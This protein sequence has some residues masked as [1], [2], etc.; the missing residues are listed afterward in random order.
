MIEFS[1]ID[2]EICPSLRNKYSEKFIDEFCKLYK[3]RF[4]KH[5]DYVNKDYVDAIKYTVKYLEKGEH[6]NMENK[7]L[8]WKEIEELANKRGYTLY[9]ST[10][11]VD[12]T[13]NFI[14]NFMEPITSERLNEGKM[15]VRLHLDV[16][17]R[18]NKVEFR[19]THLTVK[20]AC[21]FTT[22]WCGSFEDE[23]HFKKHEEIFRTYAQCLYNYDVRNGED[24]GW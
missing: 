10:G 13:D 22:D 8:T 20:G 12:N 11:Q 9:A 2:E 23:Q 3:G 16:S 5:D 15:K 21:R 4:D 1:I 19:F 6:I 18:N 7:Y 17:H 14:M 24:Y